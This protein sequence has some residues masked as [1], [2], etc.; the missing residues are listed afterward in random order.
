MQKLL[1]YNTTQWRHNI[2]VAHINCNVLLI[3]IGRIRLSDGQIVVTFVRRL[4]NRIESVLITVSRVV[5]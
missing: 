3:F 5:H 4:R 2:E 1:L